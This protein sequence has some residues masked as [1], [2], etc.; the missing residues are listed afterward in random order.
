MAELHT[1]T[2]YHELIVFKTHQKNREFGLFFNVS[3]HGNNA[4]RFGK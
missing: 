3:Y 2:S 1:A 4:T